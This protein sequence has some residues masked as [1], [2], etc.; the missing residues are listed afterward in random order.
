M[1]PICK[2][3]SIRIYKC[4]RKAVPNPSQNCS[5][6]PIDSLEVAGKMRAANKN[7]RS[8]YKN[9]WGIP[10]EGCFQGLPVSKK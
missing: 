5:N 7:V 6:K 3:I 8:P 1:K 9:L 10:V 2:W 4:S